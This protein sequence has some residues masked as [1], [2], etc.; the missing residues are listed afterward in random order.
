MIIMM[1]NP[2]KLIRIAII[3]ILTQTQIGSLGNR[4]PSVNSAL[5]VSLLN[6]RKTL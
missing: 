4:K 5:K 2:G 3:T 6:F 1:M